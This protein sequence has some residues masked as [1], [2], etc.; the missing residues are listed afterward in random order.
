MAPDD[1]PLD[2]NVLSTE[3][4]LLLEVCRQHRVPFEMM[5]RLRDTE[6]KF[7]HLKR[8]HGLPE[9]MRDIVRQSVRQEEA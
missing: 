1:D 8:R 7:G 5:R 9:E 6:D 3:D 2:E 4:R